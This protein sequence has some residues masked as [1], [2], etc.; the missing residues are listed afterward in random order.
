M[1]TKKR[2]KRSVKTNQA[3]ARTLGNVVDVLERVSGALEGGKADE[4]DHLGEL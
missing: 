2:E 3:T 4:G 1:S